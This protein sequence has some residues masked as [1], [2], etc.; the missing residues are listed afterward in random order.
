MRT[1]PVAF[2]QAAI[3]AVTGAAMADT[4]AIAKDMATTR[5]DF[6]DT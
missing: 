2:T 1:A 4:A 3:E 6:E 5:T